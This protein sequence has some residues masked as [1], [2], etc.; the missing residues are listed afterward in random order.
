MIWAIATRAVNWLTSGV[1]DRALQ[2]YAQG[3]SVTGEVDKEAIRASKDTAI[4][5]IELLKLE[6][7]NWLTRS[8]RPLVTIPFILYL[9]KLVLWD[10]II[11]SFAR[12]AGWDSGLFSTDPLSP[13]LETTMAAVLGTYFVMRS[14]EK[15]RP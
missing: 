11:G 12:W 9:W 14:F 8:I 4:A 10:K 15:R 7:G 2:V 6:Q 13:M 1:L 3:Q 5:Q